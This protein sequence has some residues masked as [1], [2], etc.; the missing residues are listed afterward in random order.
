M[1]NELVSIIVVNYNGKEYLKNCV[2]SVLKN[3]YS[4]WEIIIV[5]NAS[6]DGSLEVV[7]DEFGHVPNLRVVK[8]NKNDGPA[9]ARNVG[10][11]VAKG[12]IIGF[13]DNDTEVDLNWIVCAMKY[14]RNDPKTG[15]L[16]CKLLMLENKKHFDYAGEYL[17]SLG[18][19]VHRASFREEDKGQYDAP[20]EILAA[21]S[22]GMFIRK[23][24][25]DKI[26]GFDKDYFI[27]VEETDLG[28]RT[29]LAGYRVIFAYDSIVFHHFSATNKIVDPSF[30]NFLV[31]FHGTKNYIL[32]LYKNLSSK[33]L[34]IILP[35]H[36]F[37]WFGLAMYLLLR[38]NF[39]SSWNI[40]KG[41]LWN[42]GNFRQS[43]AKRKNIQKSRV[44]SDTELFSKIYRKEGLSYY[45]KNFLGSQKQGR[46]PENENG[47]TSI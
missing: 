38:G 23:D 2:S 28:W 47:Y 46:T 5:D 6:T 19:L 31:R 35:K 3:N 18:F 43:H 27:F 4:D 10:V 42:I 17:S 32:T 11:G 37:L 15:I 24:I 25:F 41:I 12:K 14:F 34:V 20:S 22:A 21:K 16:Q 9:R 33:N 8:L 39:S 13:L 26:G 1:T 30:N 7:N 44:I 29:W 36:V 40:L 45:M